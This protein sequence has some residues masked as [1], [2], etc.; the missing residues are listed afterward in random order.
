MYKSIFNPKSKK[1][2]KLNT[3]KGKSILKKYI[4]KGGWLSED[5]N[6]EDL[7][8][9][10]YYRFGFEFETCM[11]SGWNCDGTNDWAGYE[12][13]ND[14]GSNTPHH[15][16]PTEDVSI[17]CKNRYNDKEFV[18][19]VN[20][21]YLWNGN[22]GSNGYQNWGDGQTEDNNGGFQIDTEYI[23]INDLL[24]NFFNTFYNSNGEAIKSNRCKLIDN[25]DYSEKVS[26]CGFHTHISDP[27]IDKTSIEGRLLLIEISALWRGVFGINETPTFGSNTNTFP[28][29]ETYQGDNERIQ[30][31]FVNENLCRDKNSYASLLDNINL[32]DYIFALN[33]TLNGNEQ[34]GWKNV[35][36]ADR[37][38]TLNTGINSWAE[39][40]APDPSVHVEFRGHDDIFKR[41]LDYEHTTLNDKIEYIKYY[42]QH[43]IQLFNAAKN[44]MLLILYIKNTLYNWTNDKIVNLY[45]E[46]LK[47][48]VVNI[49]ILRVKLYAQTSTSLSLGGNFA[50]VNLP[51]EINHALK[52][53]FNSSRINKITTIGNGAEAI[54]TNSMG[55]EWFNKMRECFFR[56]LAYTGIADLYGDGEGIVT[57]TSLLRMFSLPDPNKVGPPFIDGGSGCGDVENAELSKDTIYYINQELIREILRRTYATITGNIYGVDQVEN[58]MKCLEEA[59]INSLY[60][61]IYM[62]SFE[63]L[64][65]NRIGYPFADNS[66]FAGFTG[67]ALSRKTIE[68]IQKILNGF[69]ISRDSRDVYIL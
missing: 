14:W 5:P 42:L 56:G 30:T 66:D 28:F 10:R 23:D 3:L 59:N 47:V 69:G 29:L 19:H 44:R 64:D 13:T 53:R 48:G 41:F 15:L 63:G 4:K 60:R 25:G 7:K 21:D 49:E 24:S 45:I 26:S 34:D 16:I 68:T 6:I 36:V 62:F 18:N 8:I 22:I 46:L 58:M 27:Y 17:Q 39:N 57:T 1:N 12:H 67:A 33:D 54:L 51:I 37:Y 31:V 43:L 40:D 50:N 32:D 55:Y 2:I 35:C 61:F 65:V 52:F 11:K 20:I 38:S 9:D